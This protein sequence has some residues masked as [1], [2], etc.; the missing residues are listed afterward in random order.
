MGYRTVFLIRGFFVLLCLITISSE[1]KA[2][3]CEAYFTSSREEGK[4]HIISFWPFL[5]DRWGAPVDVFRS[6][7][8]MSVRP[9]MSFNNAGEMVFLWIALS[10]KG[11]QLYSR[12]LGVDGNWNNRAFKF[13][14]P[15]GEKSTPTLFRALDNSLYAAWVSDESGD[16][17]IYMVKWNERAL[18]ADIKPLNKNNDVPDISPTFRYQATTEGGLEL[19]LQWQQLSKKR[20]SYGDQSVVVQEDEAVRVDQ[21]FINQCESKFQAAG[22]PNG[23]SLGMLYFPAKLL[24]THSVISKR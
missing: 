11:F 12:V 20:F 15:K 23:V 22:L 1:V 3:S 17:D 18:E 5:E 14:N 2:Y 13:M 24:D 16:D 7:V 21:E 8:K 9:T 19:V 6:S 10:Q 4:D